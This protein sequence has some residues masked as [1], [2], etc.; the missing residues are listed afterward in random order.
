MKEA[1]NGEKTKVYTEVGDFL[2]CDV[3]P[4]SIL[5]GKGLDESGSSKAQGC[6]AAPGTPGSIFSP[7]PWWHPTQIPFL[8]SLFSATQAL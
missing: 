6:Q 4:V 2:F 5:R 1:E 7:P 8:S 3:L